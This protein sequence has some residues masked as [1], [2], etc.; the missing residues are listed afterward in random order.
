MWA[1]TISGNGVPYYDPEDDVVSTNN[2]RYVISDGTSIL[3]TIN[4][5]NMASDEETE[6]S[7][8]TQTSITLGD[9][10]ARIRL[11]FRLSVARRIKRALN[12]VA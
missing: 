12:L 9:G 8:G 10:R 6:M 11:G 1:E 4:G 3:T 2:A 5:A 7:P